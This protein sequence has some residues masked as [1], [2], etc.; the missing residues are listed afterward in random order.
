MGP[1]HR[2]AAWLWQVCAFGYG[3]L[4][5]WRHCYDRRAAMPFIPPMLATR[6]EDPRRLADPRYSAEPKLGGHPRRRG[7]GRRR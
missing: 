6:L 1:H 4:R 2:R 7:G 5:A 3:R